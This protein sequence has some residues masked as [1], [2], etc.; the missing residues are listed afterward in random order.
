LDFFR[1]ISFPM[2]SVVAMGRLA[3]LDGIAATAS[4]CFW[5]AALTAAPLLGWLVLSRWSRNGE[6]QR[7]I[8]PLPLL[9]IFYAVVSLHFQ[10]PI[11][12]FYSLSVT[13]AALLWV[14]AAEAG[15]GR[16]AV[17]AC[18]ALAVAGL[19]FQAGQ[20]TAR[21]L[22]GLLSG[23]RIELVAADGVPQA[24][25]YI[26]P[27]ESE[28]YAELLQLV[29]R[30]TDPRDAILA[31][32]VNPE[33]Y[34]LTGR[35]NPFRFFNSALGI[36]NEA[37]LRDVLEQLQDRPPAFVFHR[38]DDKYNTAASAAIMDWVRQG[39]ERLPAVHGFEVYRRAR[40]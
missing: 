29:Q 35:R 28:T 33:L 13:L 12:L 16:V 17:A 20:P 25:L 6:Y 40:H 39:Y 37:E 11:Y 34:Y 15:A 2:L 36:G 7:P 8:P 14:T 5:L 38:P 3:E 32:P 19:Y 9:A 10:I 22:D 21:G 23:A 30:E 27:E 1:Q 24:G 18:A 31:L 4:V 26:T